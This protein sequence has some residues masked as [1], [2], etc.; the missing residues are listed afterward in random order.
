MTVQSIGNIA[1]SCIRPPAVPFLAWPGVS[2]LRYATALALANGVWF[3]LVFAGCD[4][5]TSRRALRLHVN[6]PGELGIPFIAPMTAF[7]MSMYLLFIAGP[8]ILRTRRELRAAIAMLA[9]STAIAGVCF[10]LFP[11]ELAYP[12]VP[13]SELG[14]WGGLF[15]VAD[16]LNLTYDLVPSLHVALTTGCVAVF[17][18]RASGG[19]SALLWSWAVGVALSTVLIHQHHVVDVLSGWLLAIVS[20]RLVY[21]PLAAS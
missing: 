6:L 9:V 11:V 17:A 20:F 2:H 18:S 16:A 15:H 5:L 13:E 1:Q 7:Y 21:K 19:I 12:S 8:F 4:F 3:E 10:L 14:I